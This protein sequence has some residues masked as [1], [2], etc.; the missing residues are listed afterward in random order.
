VTDVLA[1]VLEDDVDLDGKAWAATV[2]PRDGRVVLGSP[3]PLEAGDVGVTQAG[4]LDPEAPS[5]C[6]HRRGVAGMC[7]K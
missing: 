2:A 5:L 7:D 1:S 3:R 4:A 6:L